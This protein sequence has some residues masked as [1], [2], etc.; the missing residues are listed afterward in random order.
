[1]F[2][3]D[4]VSQTTKLTIFSM[5]R[6]TRTFG[7]RP[8]LGGLHKLIENHVS[9]IPSWTPRLR[10]KEINGREWNQGNTV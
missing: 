2:G 5:L 4:E 9:K 1:M 7:H 3:M 6:L 10:L 8:T